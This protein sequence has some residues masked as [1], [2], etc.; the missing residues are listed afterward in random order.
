M[1]HL[2]AVWTGIQTVAEVSNW[3]R[4]L[5]S[6][7]TEVNIQELSGVRTGTLS[8]NRSGMFDMREQLVT[9]LRRWT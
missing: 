5:E 7:Q 2:S 3:E 1:S 8:A 4:G 6:T 9:E